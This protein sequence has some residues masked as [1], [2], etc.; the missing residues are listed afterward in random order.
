[1]PVE[2]GTEALVVGAGIGGLSAALAL[3]AR[4]VAVRVLE[5]ADHPVEFAPR[6][7]VSGPL[8]GD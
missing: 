7:L 4:G 3:A 2:P 6:L 8:K 1:M 5:A